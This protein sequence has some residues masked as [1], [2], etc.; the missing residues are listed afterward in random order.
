VGAVLTRDDVRV[1]HHEVLARD[2][3]GA[4]LDAVARLAVDQHGRAR[5]A[6][7]GVGGDAVGG[8]CPGVG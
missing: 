3:A 2:E 8:R 7:G 5:D 1:R 6:S 4:L